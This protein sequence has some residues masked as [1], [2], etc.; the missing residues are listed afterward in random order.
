M[1]KKSAET[2]KQKHPTGFKRFL[3]DTSRF[4]CKIRAV[5]KPHLPG[6]GELGLPSLGRNIKLL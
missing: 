1:L 6:L 4:L 5:R 2:P 3:K